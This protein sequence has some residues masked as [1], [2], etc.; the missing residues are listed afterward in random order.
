[1]T[2]KPDNFILVSAL[3]V[4][5][6]CLVGSPL[7]AQTP[8]QESPQQTEIVTPKYN[9]WKTCVSDTECVV[10]GVGCYVDSANTAHQNEADAY[11]R[12]RNAPVECEM[13]KPKDQYIARC[14]QGECIAE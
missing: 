4:S 10:V 2:K 11:Y 3:F 8:T 6:Y 12:R 13:K 9:E 7:A 1:M 14:I 5:A